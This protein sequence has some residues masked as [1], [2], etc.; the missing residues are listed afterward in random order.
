MDRTAVE[1]PI[2][3]PSRRRILAVAAGWMGAAA[4]PAR[5]LAA[6]ASQD[7]A[8]A[9]APSP[10]VSAEA[11]SARFLAAV[12]TGDRETAAAVLARD[13]GLRDVRDAAG[14]SAFA[15][16]LLAGHAELGRWLREQG[17]AP[18]LHESALA[19]DWPRFETLAAVA[20]AM[21]GLDHPVG[22]PALWA[23]ARGGAA[24]EVWRPYGFGAD[25][26]ANPR[27]AAGQTPLRAAFDHPDLALAER[28]AAGLLA[29]GA[30]PNAP[31]RD[32]SSPLHAA[33]ARGSVESCRM[34]LRKGAD[35]GARDAAGRTPHEVAE[36][37]PALAAGDGPAVDAGT[38]FA[39]VLAL[40]AAPERVV[41]DH[42]TS[43]T[44]WDAHGARFAPADL[45][46]FDFVVQQR[47][48]GM[49][50]G[51][52]DGV[53]GLVDRHGELARAVATTGE[54]AVEASAHTGQRE[55]VDY[56]LERGAPYSLL[57]AVMRDD[58]PRVRQLLDED[59]RRIHERGPHDFALLWYP[60][61][62]GGLLD[63][64]GL[65]LDRGAEIEQQEHLGTTALHW[66]VRRGQREMVALLLDRGANPERASR[67]FAAQ[68]ETPLA[69][70]LA[71][72]HAAVADLLRARGARR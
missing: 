5:V 35:A 8:A 43:R 57:T 13:P 7:A 16:A 68:G 12:A 60:V 53:R 31:Q 14:R 52:F 27:G 38:R 71:R 19:L 67:Q 1:S 39:A 11:P 48:V 70:A 10:A 20:P 22:G 37:A 64:A 36:R 50:H 69:I 62:G 59:P 55:I 34:L 58:R 49:S 3:P 33:A 66:A 41:R 56:L 45:S 54:H 23:A 61:I 44:A 51:N 21:V 40:L 30:D 9:G 4:L 18:D 28:T 42:S 26:N 17:H 46:A 15:I 29:N 2:E 24:E 6:G 72:G 32:G 47:V 65:L 63:L 25:P